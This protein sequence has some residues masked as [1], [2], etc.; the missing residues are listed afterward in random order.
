MF[1]T[2][3]QYDRWIKNM[4][5]N[6]TG[7]SWVYINLHTR[8]KLFQDDEKKLYWVRGIERMYLTIKEE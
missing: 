8:C 6:K 4:S 5:K 7:T 3:E 1:I 2:Q